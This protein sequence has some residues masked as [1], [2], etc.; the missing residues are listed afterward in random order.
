MIFW[1]HVK[2]GIG[3]IGSIEDIVERCRKYWKVR[4]EIAHVAPFESARQAVYV[5][6]SCQ[7]LI[8]KISGSRSSVVRICVDFH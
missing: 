7:I 5:L 3:S 1:M 6:T 8:L 2:I 4:M